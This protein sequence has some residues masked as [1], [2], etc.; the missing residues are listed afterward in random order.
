[1]INETGKD[2]GIVLTG[3]RN[4]FSGKVVNGCVDIRIEF[5]LGFYGKHTQV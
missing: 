5:V 4:D 2:H 3:K 1:M